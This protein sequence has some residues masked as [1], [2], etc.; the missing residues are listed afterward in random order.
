MAD[1]AKM[2]EDIKTLTL[3]EINDLVKALE[4]E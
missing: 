2:I 3:V 4:E 1:I